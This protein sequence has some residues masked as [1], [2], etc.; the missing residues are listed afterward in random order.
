MVHMKKTVAQ[1]GSGYLPKGQR[2]AVPGSDLNSKFLLL[3][4]YCIAHSHKEL[5]VLPFSENME[6]RGEVQS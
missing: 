5:R 2:M 4:L 3:T 1:R 6:R